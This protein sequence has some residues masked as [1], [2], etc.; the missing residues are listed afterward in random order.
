MERSRVAGILITIIIALS[1][2]QPYTR[3]ATSD[4]EPATV[5]GVGYEWNYNTV[6]ALDPSSDL[7]DSN[8]FYYTSRDLI[9]W[10]YMVGSSY[11]FMRLDFLDL[12][13][14]AEVAS[15]TGVS[16]ALN[17]YI[18]IGWENAQGYQ[19]WVPDYVK[20]DG[21]GVYLSD[22]CWVLSIAIYDTYNY[23]VYDYNWNA[24]LENSG[25]QVA[26]NSQWDLVEVAVPTSLLKSY[27][28]T[29]TTR[30]WAKIATTI[31][32]SSGGSVLA[33]IMPNSITDS[34]SYYS[35][36][37]AVFS[38]S[39][40][41]TAKL[42]IVHHGNQHL[43]DNTGYISSP[44]NSY[45]HILWIHED[46]SSK[47]G[48]PVP[49]AIHMSGT[50]LASYLWYRPDFID[51]IKSLVNRGIVGIVGGVWAEYIT[52]YFYD[53][54]NA[55][56]AYIA[57]QYYS[58]VFGVAPKT[59]WIPERT[60][61]DERT[62]IAW[63]LSKY[64]KAVILDGNTHHDDWDN[65]YPH[66]KVHKYDTRRTEGR[67]LYVFFIDWDTQQ[68]LLDNTDNGLNIDLRKKFLS[69]AMNWDQQQVLVYAD[70]WEKAAGIADWTS[71]NVYYYENSIRWIAMHPWIQVVT[72]DE[73]VSWL[74][75]G[76]WTPVDGFYCGYDTYYYVKTW[77][78]RYPYDYRRAYD[79][80]YWGTPQEEAFAALG[81]S[82]VTIGGATVPGRTMPDT[83]MPL[84]DV[85]G[86]TS[87]DGSPSNTVIYRLLA[88]GGLLDSA[89]RNE[90]WWLAVVTANSMLY[91]TAWH[92]EEDANGDGLHDT[93][94][95]GRWVWNHL[96][97]VNVLLIAA[98]W[99]DQV[100]KGQVTGVNYMTGD[101]DWDGRSEV[102]V[103]NKYIMAFIDQRGGAVPYVFVYEPGSN[104]AYMAVGAP[105]VYWT[106]ER[107]QWM[108]DKHWGIFVDDYYEATG[109]N[110]YDKDYSVTARYDSALNAAI[111]ELT[112]PDLDGDEEPDF[113][114]YISLSP[115]SR[116]LYV[117]Y[118]L[119]KPGKLYVSMGLSVDPWASLL[120]GN[121]LAQVGT[122]VGTQVFG[123]VNNASGARAYVRPVQYASYTGTQDLG[124]ETL[125]Y[126]FKIVVE[127]SDSYAVVQAMFAGVEEPSPAPI[128]EPWLVSA[129]SLL[130]L[131]LVAVAI[132]LSRRST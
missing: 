6:H 103:Y 22:Y 48:R 129:V 47:T 72:P 8:S 132:R 126:R 70:D 49:V 38:D 86:Y 45:W 64:Y 9:A 50:L 95:W 42:I 61:D 63:T 83:I 71:N 54:F 68:H 74:D 32:Y 29:T 13:Y 106:T 105:M 99:L 24:K 21:K 101:F 97:L 92:L 119:T 60:W 85:L 26:F 102:I 2:I 113:Y 127:S 82:S 108:N 55:P 120:N 112:P 4:S 122:P 84:G 130:V 39:N 128:P 93:A 10:Y 81:A 7:L 118:N 109:Y 30:V 57:Q 104:K 123:Y 27:G 88:P 94:Y 19:C 36:S 80:W 44:P 96:R 125:Q 73:V 91:E 16:D 43:T 117:Y 46:V 53:N 23:K 131:L 107:D 41:G 51:Y 114:K 31:V 37:G 11:V 116:S 34:G 52:A 87:Y 62:G 111:V 40:V 77:V 12:A 20:Y 121:N 17:I 33:D 90:F 79:G 67:T 76:S 59:A 5:D 1:M 110:Y 65:R 100:R 89:P 78:Q 115:D 66:T 28:W 124:M 56:S 35:W 69:F 98:N 58:S 15:T 3:L 25:L 75:K 18:M 14:G